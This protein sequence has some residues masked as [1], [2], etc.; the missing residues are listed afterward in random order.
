[1]RIK[2]STVIK[3]YVVPGAIIIL[4]LLVLPWLLREDS[5]PE[6]LIQVN[7]RLE[8]DRITASTE[9]AGRICSLRAAEGDQVKAGQIMVELDDDQM[10]K[11]LSQAQDALAAL[12]KQ[13]MAAEIALR[14]QKEEMPLT[15]KKAESGVAHARAELEKAIATK[16]KALR[17]VKR[18]RELQPSGAMS[19]D[20]LEQA[21][22][23][24]TAANRDVTIAQAALTQVQAEL[25]S[26]KLEEER[27]KAQHSRLESLRAERDK[28]QSA[29]DEICC[30]ID[31]Y[32]I[33][34]P[35]SGTVTAKLVSLGETLA[36]STPLFD[37]VD[38][39]RLY[40]KAY[41]PEPD[42]GKVKLGL[43]AHIFTDAFPSRPFA[44]EV[45]YIASRAQ[46]T[47]KD[48]QTQE[49]RVKQ[50]FA[51]KLHIEEN[52]DRCLSP[53]MQADAVIRWKNEVPWR[54]PVK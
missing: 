35:A 46:F 32:V 40:L 39:D 41:V 19:E 6:G 25:A 28:A 33:K 49:A 53:G 54:S 3:R 38:L 8:A 30:I 9:Y 37:M 20:Q 21:E 45:A 43:K 48:V 14:V 51:I 17:D 12:Q 22:L 23:K 13:V 44:A 29:V 27:I 16:E 4:F 15:I 18:D 26:S 1:M 47:P 36:P 5:L 10:Q 31:K 52:P 2:L 7:G 24:W 11:R 34:A 42:I 50:V